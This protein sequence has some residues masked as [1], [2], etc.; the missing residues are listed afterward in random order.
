MQI[1]NGITEMEI[2]ILKEIG[3]PYKTTDNVYNI[4]IDQHYALK[5]RKEHLVH[6]KFPRINSE[7]AQFNIGV[8]SVITESSRRLL[9]REMLNLGIENVM[10]HDT[11]SI[12][13]VGNNKP[14]KVG[15]KL[16]N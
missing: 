16:G 2:E 1:L 13:Y 11:D 15:K 12:I 5:Q 4:S 10:Y 14:S 7:N 6:V 9:I 8:A 3:V